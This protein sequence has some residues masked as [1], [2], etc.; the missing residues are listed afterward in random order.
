MALPKI[1][2]G[3]TNGNIGSVVSTVDGVFGLLASAKAIGTFALDTPYAIYGMADVAAMGI[4]ADVENYLLHKTLREFYE[5]AGEGTKLWLI[6][7]GQDTKVSDWFTPVAGVAPV[8]ALLKK[9]NGEITCLFTSFSPDGDYVLT[10][11]DGLDEDVVL[12]RTKAQ[13]LAEL[14]VTTDFAPLFVILEGYGFTGVHADLLDLKLE[15]NNRVGVFLGD[16]GKRTDAVAILGAAGHIFA[17]RLAS[18]QV[19][20]NAGKVKNGSLETLVAYILDAAVESYN[21][22]ALH[23]K[24]YI[25]FRTHVRKAGYYF[26][27]DPLATAEDD[28][29]RSIARRRVIDK[30]FRLAHNV[31]SDEILNDFDLKNDGTLSPLFAKDV[32]GNIERAI[33]QG[34]T[35]KGELSADPSN[36]DDLGVIARFDLIKDVSTTNQID[37]TIQVRPKGYAR[38]FEIKLGYNVNLNE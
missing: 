8:D 4:I 22:E 2:I 9:A 35:A 32:E 20:E 1:N 24:G 37:L 38:F 16:T 29:Y 7:F 33:A 6:G 25:T 21:V 5:Q 10:I 19:H 15:E 28:D 36:S 3:F 34:M 26:T 23:D 11:A 30:A 27:D 14:Y 13:A 31:A 17:A 12:A 18:T